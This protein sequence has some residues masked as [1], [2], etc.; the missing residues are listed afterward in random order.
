VLIS[1]VNYANKL[2]SDLECWKSGI[3][4]SWFWDNGIMGLANQNDYN[5]IGFLD[6]GVFSRA[7]AEKKMD[8]CRASL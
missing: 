8:V 7:K 5:C 1:T 3:L 2:F 4:E 6:S